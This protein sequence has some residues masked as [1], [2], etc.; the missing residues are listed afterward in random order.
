[1]VSCLLRRGQELNGLT[2][3]DSEPMTLLKMGL[4]ISSRA[5]QRH[6]LIIMLS[7][8]NPAGPDI[9]CESNPV[10]RGYQHFRNFRDVTLSISPTISYNLTF[11][12]PVERAMPLRKRNI[13][14]FPPC[15]Q[16]TKCLFL[17][18]SGT[19]LRLNSIFPHNFTTG[20]DA[21]P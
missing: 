6:W 19:A 21:E 13:W 17:F 20:I 8:C 5:P 4:N 9:S 3:R 16:E 18:L 10:G 14:S 12:S 11:T 1:M 2:V 7:R 15:F